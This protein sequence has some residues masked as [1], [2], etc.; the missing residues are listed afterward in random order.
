MARFI[1]TLRRY[2]ET[3]HNPA[4]GQHENALRPRMFRGARSNRRRRSTIGITLP[5]KSSRRR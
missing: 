4:N 3:R 1:S 2:K 5:R